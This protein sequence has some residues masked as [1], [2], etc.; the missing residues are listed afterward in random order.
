MPMKRL[1]KG[2]L[3]AKWR[4]KIREKIVPLTVTH[5]YGPQTV[6]LASNEAAVTCVIKNG[7]FYIEAFIKHYSQ[8]GFRHIFFLDNGSTDQTI[9]LARNYKNVSVC[10]SNLSI[11]TNQTLLKKYLAQ[12]SVRGGWCLDADIDEFFDYPCSDVLRLPEFLA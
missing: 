10:K 4:R 2:L 11:Q 7:E 12:K 1:L 8:F 6:H 5:V 9:S 3:P